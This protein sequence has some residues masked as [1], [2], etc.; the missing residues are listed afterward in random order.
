M[1][2]TTIFLSLGLAGTSFEVVR[3]FHRVKRQ[4]RDI[5]ALERTVGQL[6]VYVDKTR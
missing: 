3:L 6:A 2:W 1:D 5:E 4:G